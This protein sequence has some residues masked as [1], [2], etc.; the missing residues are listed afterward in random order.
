MD[1]QN[2]MRP[3]LGVTGLSLALAVMAAVLTGRSIKL[4]RRKPCWPTMRR[5]LTKARGWK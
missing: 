4:H 5:R 3:L 2:L 1:V